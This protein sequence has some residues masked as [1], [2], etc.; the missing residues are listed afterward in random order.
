MNNTTITEPTVTLQPPPAPALP[1]PVIHTYVTLRYY[2]VLSPSSSS[3][4]NGTSSSSRYTHD[5]YKYIDIAHSIMYAC[6]YN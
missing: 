2:S 6:M 5:M 1:C 4:S 3:S